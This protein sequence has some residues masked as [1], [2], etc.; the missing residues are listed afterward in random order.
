MR[1]SGFFYCLFIIILPVISLSGCAEL[2][3]S[4]STNRFQ[5]AVNL[6]NNSIRW[7]DWNKVFQLMQNKPDSSNDTILSPTAEQLEHLEG[8]K[9]VRVNILNTMIT[10]E[11]KSAD[12]VFVIEYRRT[13][14]LKVHSVRHNTSWWFNDEDNI[15]YTET[16]LP[17]IFYPTPNARKTIKYSP[18]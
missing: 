15:W 2:D 7:H 12:V 14:S 6:Y 1:N 3:S 16:A 18:Q 4:S 8:F 13:N 11:D 5:S 17:E 9:I 10:E